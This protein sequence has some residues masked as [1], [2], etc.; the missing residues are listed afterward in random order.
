MGADN[1]TKLPI[2]NITVE[3]FCPNSQNFVDT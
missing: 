2:R 1:R 3:T